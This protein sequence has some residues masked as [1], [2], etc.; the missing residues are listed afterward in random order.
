[1]L[2]QENVQGLPVS[3]PHA[4]KYREKVEVERSELI[5]MIRR[6]ES[7]KLALNNCVKFA[8]NMQDEVLFLT[9]DDAQLCAKNLSDFTAEVYRAFSYPVLSCIG[10]A[11]KGEGFYKA[12]VIMKMDSSG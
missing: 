12:K 3:T 6:L 1:M 7:Y 2:T 11:V 9:E 4:N 5:S 8:E 10:K